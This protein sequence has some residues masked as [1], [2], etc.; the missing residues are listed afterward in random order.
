[1]GSLERTLRSRLDTPDI[2][3][4][5]VGAVIVANDRVLLL[6]RRGGDF[7]EGLWELPSGKMEERECPME[8][9]RRE[10]MEETG[11][12]IVRVAGYAGDF[13]YLSRSGRRTRQVNLVVQP[14]HSPVLLSE[15]DAFGWFTLEEMGWLNVSEETAACVTLGVDIS[16]LGTG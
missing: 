2:D 16:T 7:L 4:V 14:S 10:V 5:V 13:D 1:M 8:A 6:R 12:E 9:L 11:L 3:R 15:H